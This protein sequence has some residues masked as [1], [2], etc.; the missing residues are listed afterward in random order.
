MTLQNVVPSRKRIRKKKEAAIPRQRLK[1][2]D[3]DEVER[4]RS[5]QSQI[6]APRTKVIEAKVPKERRSRYAAKSGKPAALASTG[7]NANSGMPPLANFMSKE[8]ARQG[9]LVHTLIG[10]AELTL[11]KQTSLP[12]DLL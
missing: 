11:P 12:L 5:L 9:T 3:E 2:K 7:R 4:G 10:L 6:P 1:A 8:A